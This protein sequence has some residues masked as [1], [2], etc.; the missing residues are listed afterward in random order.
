MEIQE[1]LAAA[2]EAERARQE[3]YSFFMQAPAPMVIFTGKD[4]HFTLANPEYEK[5][6]GRKVSGKNLGDVFTS[7]EISYYTKLLNDVYETG[8]PFVGRDLFLLLRDDNGNVKETRID[9]SY[10]PLRDSENAVRGILV[11]VQ[12]VT[13]QYVARTQM[14]RRNRELNEAKIDAERA[15]DA[16]SAFLANMSHEIR[17]PLGAIMGFADLARQPGATKDDI[18]TYLGVVERNSVQVL[19][20]IDDILDLAKVEAGRVELESID[21]SLSELLADF[22]SLMA[23]RA[24]ENGIGF[25]IKAGSDLPS[26]V[27]VDPTRLRQ[28][29]TN[30]VG[31]AIKFTSKGSVTVHVCH[32]NGSLYFSVEDTGRGVSGEQAKKLFQAFVQADVSTTRKFGGTGLGLVLT[33]RLCQLMGGDYVLEWS[34]I[35]VGSKFEASIKAEIPSTSKIISKDDVVFESSNESAPGIVRGRLDELSVLLVED[36]PDN[37]VLLRLILES[38]GA[39]LD[40]ASDGRD[41]V[42]KA[43]AK[44]YDV[45]LM[46]IQMP[47]MDGHEAVRMLR[48]KGYN[49]PV[50]AL[51]AH[52]MRDEADRAIAS[53]FTAFLSKPIQRERLVSMVGELGQKPSKH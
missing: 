51:T 26:R 32:K 53:G 13:E 9:V 44:H 4:H 2:D 43:M 38:N 23:F 30:A 31:N 46:D 25:H 8:Q 48:S 50:V 52:A 6:V 11:F 10:T 45:V 22:G 5:Y 36:S 7:E 17:T 49:R 1:K 47:E 41:G 21:T 18:K 16:K 33:K 15:N 35:G 42:G 34:E 29:L 3:L 19:R 12:D 39:R 14:E 37:Q 27:T 40:I 24:R 28:V 20:I